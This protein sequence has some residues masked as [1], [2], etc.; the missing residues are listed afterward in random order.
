MYLAGGAWL[1]GTV[2]AVHVYCLI[3]IRYVH[4]VRDNGSACCRHA[5]DVLLSALAPLISETPASRHVNH[6]HIPT[7]DRTTIPR[8][9]FRFCSCVS[10]RICKR[11]TL[12]DGDVITMPGACPPCSSTMYYE[13]KYSLDFWCREALSTFLLKH[14]N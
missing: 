14:H 2:I 8:V 11:A 5:V 6:L 13:G 3:P 4:F 10:A 1:S 7:H 12:V 9:R